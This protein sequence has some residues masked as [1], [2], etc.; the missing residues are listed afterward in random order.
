MYKRQIDNG[1]SWILDFYS[2]DGDLGNQW[3]EVYLDLSNFNS[4]ELLIRFRVITGDGSMGPGWQGDVAIDQVSILSGPVTIDGFFLSDYS[5][6]IINNLQYSIQGCDDLLN[7]TIKEV[8]AGNDTSACPLQNPFN[9]SGI[10]SG[11]IWSGNYITNQTNGTF[12]PALASG[13]SLI[14]I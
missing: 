14:H 4:S 3:N 12:D 7:I 6:E 2:V 8:D 1:V 10:P 13:L 9:L 5:N 11:G